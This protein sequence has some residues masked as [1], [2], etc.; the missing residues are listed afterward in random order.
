MALG[1]SAQLPEGVV[2]ARTEALKTLGKADRSILPVGIG[3]YEVVQ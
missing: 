2:Q 3:Q 1:G